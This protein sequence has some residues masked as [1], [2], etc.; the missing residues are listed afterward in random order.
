MSTYV[1]LY[2]GGRAPTT[3]VERKKA[4]DEWLAWYKQLDKAVIDQGNPFTP[5][6]KNITEDGKIHDGSIGTLAT[7]YTI[8]QAMSL[9]QAVQLARSCPALHTGSKISIY[10]TYN[11]MG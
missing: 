3:D 2:T 1:L 10:E 4:T 9:D 5:M 11:A 6:A 8:I 7:G